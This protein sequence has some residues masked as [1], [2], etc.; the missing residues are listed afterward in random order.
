MLPDPVAR[1]RQCAAIPIDFAANA[2]A[3]RA[4]HDED[5]TRGGCRKQFEKHDAAFARRDGERIG[6][7]PGGP[8]HGDQVQRQ[9]KPPTLPQRHGLGAPRRRRTKHP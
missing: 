1:R 6:D 5:S 4:R 7:G 3:G 8:L 2:E 9:M